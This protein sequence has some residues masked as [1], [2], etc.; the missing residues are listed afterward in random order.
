LPT[1]KEPLARRR[2]RFQ[3][4]NKGNGKGDSRAQLSKDDWLQL[5]LEV[6]DQ[7]GIE[8]VR[9]LPLSKRLGVTRGSFYWHF[10]SREALLHEMLE[11]W[12]RELTDTVIKRVEI[13]EDPLSRLQNVLIQVML[14]QR[15]RYDRAVAAWGLFDVHVGPSYRRVV[16][17]RLE[18]LESL[19]RECDPQLDEAEVNFRAHVVVGYLDQAFNT[20]GSITEAEAE[21]ESRRC[22][23]LIL[24]R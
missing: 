21:E 16:M 13:I 7:S 9:V 15:N 17:K 6:L 18:Y 14:H 22:C 11:Y 1:R 3:S 12:E 24:H 19:I 5:A 8:A 20:R 2:E 4:D 23:D 10:E